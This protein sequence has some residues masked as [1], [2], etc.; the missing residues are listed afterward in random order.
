[1]QP[2]GRFWEPLA[3]PRRPPPTGAQIGAGIATVVLNS[4]A[5]A[6][7]LGSV[8]L[9]TFTSS[10]T[11]AKRASFGYGEVCIGAVS[12]TGDDSPSR[13]QVLNDDSAS[14]VQTTCIPYADATVARLTPLVPVGENVLAAACE[15]LATA[16]LQPAIAG[17]ILAMVLL[18]AVG[19][20]VRRA[21]TVCCRGKAN[22]QAMYACTTRTVL[23]LLVIGLCGALT[24][25]ATV[26]RLGE[27][28]RGAPEAAWLLSLRRR[29]SPS[30]PAP[31][32]FFDPRRS[33]TLRSVVDPN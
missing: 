4:I 5:L 18:L 13:S 6:T 14:A 12:A 30:P 2:G 26:S 9:A 29:R 33:C 25:V 17:S 19:V 28:G 22:A 24:T 1:L 3:C 31:L 27:S 20:H 7:G 23:L 21:C 16:D 11:P 8:D 15:Q 10:T 32:R